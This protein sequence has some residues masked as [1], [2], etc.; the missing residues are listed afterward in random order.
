ML[1]ETLVIISYDIEVGGEMRES[2]SRGW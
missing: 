1:I 2:N